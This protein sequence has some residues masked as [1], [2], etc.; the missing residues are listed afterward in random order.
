MKGFLVD[1]DSKPDTCPE[2]LK[3]NGL[4]LAGAIGAPVKVEA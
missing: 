2:G 3:A 1:I 4:D